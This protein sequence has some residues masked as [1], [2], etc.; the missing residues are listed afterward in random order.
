MQLQAECQALHVELAQKAEQL[1]AAEAHCEEAAVATRA[2][3]QL[4]CS[5]DARRHSLSAEVGKAG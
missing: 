1:A 4:A 2:A 5:A 3:E